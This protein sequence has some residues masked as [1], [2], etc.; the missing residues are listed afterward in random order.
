MQGT[1]TH[2]VMVDALFASHRLGA[3]LAQAWAPQAVVLRLQP[4]LQAILALAPPDAGVAVV[5]E[6]TGRH[7][8]ET[9][10]ALCQ[11]G[12]AAPPVMVVGP[13]TAA[14]IVLAIQAGA[15][16]YAGL[17]ESPMALWARLS[18]RL[19][20]VA[21]RQPPRQIEI[22][23][24]VLDIHRRCLVHAG[25]DLPLTTREFAVLQTLAQ[26]PNQRVDVSTLCMAVCRRSEE[27][28]KRAL[29]QSIYCLRRKLTEFLAQVGTPDA[30][31]IVTVHASGYQLLVDDTAPLQQ[32]Q[33]VPIRMSLEFALP[34]GRLPP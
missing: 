19:E 2:T 32:A 7:L 34:Q 16:D 26:Q 29:E 14:S 4:S 15:A 17:M 21:G 22:G 30:L 33:P 1:A 5:V 6:D 8:A 27:L 20:L 28:G 3:E 12:P 24:C 9:L 13:G 11:R 10:A 31:R 25:R 18:A 23:A